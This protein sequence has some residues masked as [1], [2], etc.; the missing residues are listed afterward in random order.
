YLI[1]FRE[2]L[3]A[4]FI[5]AII[6]SYLVRTHRHKLIRYIWYGVYLAIA[7]SIIFGVLIWF[8]YGV[9]AESFQLLFE[10][11]AAFIAVAVL[12]SMIYWMAIRGRYIKQEI[13]RRIEFSIKKGTIIGLISIAFIVVFREGFETVLFLTPF[14]LENAIATFLGIIIGIITA[15]MLSYGI[16]IAGM[17]IN[18][19]IFFYLTSILLI[20][21][22]GGLAGY[23]IHELLE[24]YEGTGVDIGWLAEPAYSL[25]IPEDNLLHHKN[26]V[27][28]IFAVM[29][30][31]SVNPEWAR[32]V[33]HLIYLIIMLPIVIWIY[34][35]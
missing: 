35:K 14:L 3:E 18:L 13:E 28:S 21:L 17:R 24:Y 26:I 33:V 32:V 8:L 9:L 31:Y 23:G 4:A 1:T 2:V 7:A 16:F 34:K 15:L 20:F 19:R 6:L 30:G 25:N 29:F 11:I 22:A 5:I 12:S 27:G 10:T